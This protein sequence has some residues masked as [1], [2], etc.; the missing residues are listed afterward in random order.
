MDAIDLLE[1]QHERVDQLLGQLTSRSLSDP[2]KREYVAQVADL[3]ALHASLEELHFYPAVK[4]ASTEAILRESLEE[5]LAAKRILADLLLLVPQ[6]GKF[7][8]KLELLAEE[9]RHHVKDERAQLFPL[10]R[11]LLDPDQLEAL[12]Q[13]M[14][15]TLVELE[16]GP[17]PRFDVPAQTLTTPLLVGYVGDRGGHLASRWFPRIARLLNIPMQLASMAWSGIILVR[18]IFSRT[19]YRP[20]RV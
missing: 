2:L 19:R 8:A 18:S 13:L 14:T 17:P 20:R 10:V 9:V 1:L 6:D 15:S 3:L 7:D 12:G 4:D 11:Q 16:K 5:H